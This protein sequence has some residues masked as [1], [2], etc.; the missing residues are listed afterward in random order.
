M[1]NAPFHATT[2]AWPKPGSIVSI[3]VYLVYR[4]RGIVSDQ[5]HGGKPMVISNS[6]RAGGV[7]EQPW[8]VFAE[9]R[10]V[11]LDGVPDGVPAYHVV[12]RVRSCIGTRY[13]LF[14]WNCDHL[15]AYA[16][17]LPLQSTQVDTTLAIA[18]LGTAL[19][20]IGGRASR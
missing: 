17:G 4:H 18:V 11:R 9:N 12:N 19:M 14:Q 6:A 1:G 10:I 16:Q 8:D 13:D 7:V 3:P 20:A 15:V 5:W 2:N